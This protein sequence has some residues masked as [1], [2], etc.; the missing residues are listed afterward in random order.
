M[1]AQAGRGS[2]VLFLVA[3]PKL[4]LARTRILAG[5][6]PKEVIDDEMQLAADN[7]ERDIAT[8]YLTAPSLEAVRFP[9]RLLRARDLKVAIMVLRPA[10]PDERL[11]R[12][13][14]VLCSMA[15]PN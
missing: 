1:R 2:T 12:P 11:G 10:P 4:R 5:S 14:I 13:Y 6:D 15:D 8:W 7:G 3:E 9:E